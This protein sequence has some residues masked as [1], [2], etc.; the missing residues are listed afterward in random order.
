MAQIRV[1]PNEAQPTHHI[2]LSDQAGNSL[3]LI[4]VDSQGNANIRGLSRSPLQRT[5]LKTTSGN[6]SY[7]DYDL[8][9]VSSAQTDWSGGRGADIWENDLTRYYDSKRANT[10]YE[11][12]TNGPLEVYTTGL[13]NQ[14]NN[15]PGSVMWRA[16]KSTNEYLAV[17]FA[18]SAS[19]TADAIYLLI[20]KH[21]TP[22]TLSV[23]LCSDS[24]TAT[25][26]PTTVL[27]TATITSADITDIL[28]VMHKFTITAQAV[29]SGVY[30]WIKAYA[31]EGTDDD[32][33]KIGVNN[34]TGTTKSSTDGNTWAEAAFDLYYRL[35][36]ADGTWTSILFQYKG[37]QYLVKNPATGA[38]NLY[39]NG[40]RGA[41]DAN[42]A[43]LTTLVDAT[44]AWVTNQW[45]GWTVKIVAG[46]GITENI[47]WRT[48]ISNTATTLTVDSAWTI[49][50]D[51]TT[52]YIITNGDIWYEVT[53]HGLTG[54]VTDVL[55]VN[56]IVYFA[57]GEAI[58]MRRMQHTAANVYQWDADSTNK[59][60]YLTTCR[61]SS[62]GLEIWRANNATPSSISKAT[63]AAWGV[64]LSFATAI[65]FK[66]EHGRITN[67][68]E[69][70]NYLWIMREA[71]LYYLDTSTTVP[72][73]LPLDEV[74]TLRGDNNG[75][76]TMAHDVYLVFNWGYGLERFYNGALDDIGPNSGEGLPAERQ[77]T[78]SDLVGYAGRYFASIDAGSTGYSSI[79]VNAI[80]GSG[81]S[82]HEEYRAPVAGQRILDMDF[83]VT[84]GN[85]P[86]RLWVVVGSDVIWLYQPSMTTKAK[87]DSN[88]RYTHE[89]V[90][91][92]AWITGGLVDLWKFYHS[93]KL[94]NEN[95]V[96]D[97]IEIEIGYKV[98]NN[99]TWTQITE[100]FT[101]SPTQENDLI[102]V[103][104]IN[105]KK[106]RLRWILRTNDSSISPE[107]KQSVLES[108][109]R[110][111][112]K[113]GF[114]LTFRT[115]D[116]DID[117]QG[118]QEL[119]LATQRDAIIDTWIT[120]V[121][122][123]TMRCTKARY[124]NKVVYIE[125]SPDYPTAEYEESYIDK[126]VI[127]Q[128]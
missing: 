73:K 77:G 9:W 59:A 82:W 25:P 97:E 50:H 118:N 31:S 11:S 58:A 107:V 117:L 40:D 66:D 72:A 123:L 86:D 15:L 93:V 110:V 6:M 92:S 84:E 70:D 46:T 106:I 63:V 27:Q 76:A 21:G 12:I 121:T 53:G 113:Y 49:T 47:L 42:T 90:V 67:I 128:I 91:E 3:G 4:A 114:T 127:T 2:S 7:S 14:N 69:H 79:L 19:Y 39:I 35:T 89:T 8:P 80:G 48:V 23:E 120:E 116:N 51:T 105:G 71:M 32:H 33:W 103:W 16:I 115:K 101:T 62:E 65:N 88:Y 98:D 122:P 28:S 125:P 55:V 26:T 102:D 56:E 52:E 112:V 45:A 94:F 119:L 68:L 85:A 99:A 64:N 13:R 43:D 30:Y 60:T 54:P 17:R 83:Q 18:A 78:V 124:D 24:G 100:L 109:A 95:L 34:A 75:K 38:P 104:G 57:Q 111:P 74:K 37:S 108:I 22:G 96:E 29:S 41:A 5:A 20:R 61:S 81:S 44:K 36:D 126:I 10:Y 87:R 1:S